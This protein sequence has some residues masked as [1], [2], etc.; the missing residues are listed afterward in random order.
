MPIRRINMPQ[1]RR[2]LLL[3]IRR[4]ADS[5]IETSQRRARYARELAELVKRQLVACRHDL[6]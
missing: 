2:E 5:T 6:N 3:A 4:S 1:D